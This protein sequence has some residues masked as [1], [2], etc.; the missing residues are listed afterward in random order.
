MEITLEICKDYLALT[1]PKVVVLMLFTTWVGMFLATH[2]LPMSYTHVL[3]LF[4]IACC[5]GSGAVIN[6]LIDQEVDRKM[7]R[8]RSR[9]IANNRIKNTHG[10]C[11]SVV[12][13]LL[14]SAILLAY[15]N[16]LTMVLTISGTL[17]YA[18]VYSGYLK[19]ATAQNIVLG[20]LSGAI[21][22]LLGWVAVTG[23]IDP[24]ALLLMLIIF[25]WTPPHFWALALYKYQEYEVADIP[26]LP[27]VYG[28]RITKY[29]I[30][31]YSIIQAIVTLLPYL[32]Q[33][34]G[35]LYLFGCILLNARF[36]YLAYR[37]MICDQNRLGWHLFRFSIWYLFLLFALMMLDHYYYFW[38]V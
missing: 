33:M 9:P 34:C 30:F 6:H 15:V 13:L 16:V 22:P 32:T 25:V 29:F 17:G 35:M 7:F 36:L 23:S 27:V 3:A 20:G 10:L 2:T 4:G 18:L 1:K 26:M 31:L 8:T 37:L 5:A 21:P 24:R 14:G 11:F 19:Y 28:H 38:L 12:L